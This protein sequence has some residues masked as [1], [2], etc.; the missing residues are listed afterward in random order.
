MI[1][2][3]WL[4]IYYSDISGRKEATIENVLTPWSVYEFR[5]AAWNAIGMGVPSAPS[6][7]HSTPPDRPYVFPQNIAGGG[8]KRGDLTIRWDPLRNDQQ[9]APGN[10][11]NHCS[12]FKIPSPTR[13]RNS[14]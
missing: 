3:K 14:L 7:K 10:Y 8:G 4:V 9:N 2:I 11:E 13:F 1:Q 5:V 6:P 12:I